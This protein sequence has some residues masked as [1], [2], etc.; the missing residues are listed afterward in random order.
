MQKIFKNRYFVIGI[1]IIIAVALSGGGFYFGY[2]QGIK[3]PQTVVIRGVANLEEGKLEAIDFSLFWDV[4]QTIK[5]KYVEADKIDNQ[6][7]FYGAV[8]GLLGALKDENSVFFPPTDAQKFN[9]DISG[10]FGGIG[11]EIGT[12]NNQLVIIAPL[13]NT[14]A[15]RAG[16]RA[17]DKILKVDD[18]VTA[19]LTTDE[20]VKLIR[21]QKG[22]TVILT[23]LRNGWDK[24]K[25][26]SIIRD[27]IQVPTLDWE[28]KENNIAYIHL[29]NFYEKA[30]FLF[31]QAAVEIAFKNPKGIILDLRNNPG[32]FLDAAIN[33]T[34]W[35]LKPG[36]TVV[37]EEFRSDK[38]Q[39]F[40]SYGNGLF[41]D[42]PIVILINEGS[43][44]ASEILAGAL[45]DNRSVKL[46][47]KK[48]FGKGTVQELEPL[49]DGSSIKI[50]VA[51]WRMPGG[52]L[53]EK[54][55]LDPDYEVGLTD[56]DFKANRDP[57]LEKAM[58]VLK[59]E[60]K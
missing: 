9:E 12:R 15:E 14:P 51:H 20:A 16:L 1:S 8:S 24:P 5:D 22:T 28:I 34:G 54:N 11:A 17:L 43:A 45:R 42:V 25:E 4:W 47:G 58:E 53:I 46:I 52:G 13:K 3:K 36:Q 29:Y 44:S 6:T 37:S 41:K 57:Q 19:N 21:G 49:K 2:Q 30:P 23:I 60:I 7:L 33:L 50:T 10:E 27:T 38:K 39:V 32:G 40:T 26:I 48:S 56:E 35:F 31:Y 59:S 18:T 55:G